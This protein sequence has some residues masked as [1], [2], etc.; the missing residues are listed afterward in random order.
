MITTILNS[1]FCT[2]VSRVAGNIHNNNTEHRRLSRVRERY[3]QPIRNSGVWK[4]DSVC[5]LMNWWSHL[6]VLLWFRGD[7]NRMLAYERCDKIEIE[8]LSTRRKTMW[9]LVTCDLYQRSIHDVNDEAKFMRRTLLAKTTYGQ[10]QPLAKTIRS[11]DDLSDLFSLN[12][13]G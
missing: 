4:W 5:Q 6:F 1:K 11:A 12:R 7:S 10:H 3:F 2:W 13:N 8:K 9:A